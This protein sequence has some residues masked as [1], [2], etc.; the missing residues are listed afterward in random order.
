ME[1]NVQENGT[2]LAKTIYRSHMDVMKYT[3]N[4]EEQK[5]NMGRQDEKY[6]FF[7]KQL[8]DRTY[9]KLRDLFAT[10][11]SW[12][13]IEKTN[14]PEDVKHGYQETPSGG[15][16]YLNTAEFEGFLG[17]NSDDRGNR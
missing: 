13:L 6:K 10:L 17:K 8:M 14:Y 2:E 1:L 15:S 16:G 9:S 4:L 7:K 11:E 3:L 5:Y 12:G